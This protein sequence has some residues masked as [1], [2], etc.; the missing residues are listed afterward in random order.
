ML[1]FCFQV[2]PEP[3]K[4]PGRKVKWYNHSGKVCQFLKWLTTGLPRHP[5][6]LPLGR[7][8]REMKMYVHI[9]TTQN[10][11]KV[12]TTQ[13]SIIWQMDKNVTAVK[14]NIIW[15]YEVW[16]TDSRCNTMNLGNM[17]WTGKKKSHNRPHIIYSIIKNSRIGKS[18]ETKSRSVI[19]QGWGW[20]GDS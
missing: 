18:R 13:L 12:E 6:I 3:H 19:A 14:R 7:H 9:E 11:Q 17:T 15:P 10:S 2:C 5:A 16:S 1:G 20:G 8:P 4:P